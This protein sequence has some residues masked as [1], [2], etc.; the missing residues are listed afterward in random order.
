MGCMWFELLVYRPEE[1][2]GGGGQGEGD[3]GRGKG[4]GAGG[5]GGLK[6]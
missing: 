1:L 3:R 4:L 5:K 6:S 2:G